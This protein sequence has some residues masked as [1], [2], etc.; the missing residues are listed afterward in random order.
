MSQNRK[1]IN[2]DEQAR[3]IEIMMKFKEIHDGI[4][5]LEDQMDEIKQRKEDLLGEL[6][7][8]RADDDFYQAQLEMVY[9]P[10]K[11]D[12]TTL[13][14][15]TKTEQDETINNDTRVSEDS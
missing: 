4:R 7:L 10:G 14:W 2:P 13:E 15:V 6:E 12:T 5:V 1:L 9:G 8:T 11:L 3:A